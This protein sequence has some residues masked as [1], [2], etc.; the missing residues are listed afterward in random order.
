MIAKV[1]PAV[2]LPRSTWDFD[3]LIEDDLEI[4]RGSLVEIPWR[5]KKVVG[6]VLET[7]EQ[8]D[9]PQ[10]KLKP[11]FGLLT[12]DRL[13]EDVMKALEWAAERYLSSPGLLAKRFLPTPPKRRLLPPKDLK[14]IVA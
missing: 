5:G 6:V 10:S 4:H 3:Y 9:I 11:I 7:V 12:E 14:P 13:P 1:A 8:S 2:K